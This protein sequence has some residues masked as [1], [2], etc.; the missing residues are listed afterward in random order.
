M[1]ISNT[2]DIIDSREIIERIEELQELIE[3]YDEEL[4][5]IED[6]DGEV[7]EE[8]EDLFDEREELRIL[9]EVQ[10]QGECSP[11]WNYGEILIHKNYFVEYVKEMLHDIGEFPR[12]IPWYIE[13]DWDSTAQNIKM[14]YTTIDFDGEPYYIRS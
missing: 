6:E 13:I 5:E 4:K 9:L 1:E 8:D 14:D 12:D 2:Q 11:D 3:E 7:Y 10:E